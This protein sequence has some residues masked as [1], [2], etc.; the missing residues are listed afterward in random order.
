MAIRRGRTRRL[1][2]NEAV[3]TLESRK[4]GGLRKSNEDTEWLDTSS[5]T[6]SR[7]GNW[8]E[9]KRASVGQ[10]RGIVK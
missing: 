10:K 9:E 1:F 2:V 3:Q 5:P 6:E 7:E 8:L 4:D